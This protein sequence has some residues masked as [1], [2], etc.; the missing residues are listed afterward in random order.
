ME[1]ISEENIKSGNDAYNACVEITDHVGFT[2]AL[3]DF[4]KREYGFEYKDHGDCS[5]HN[6]LVHWTKAHN[7]LA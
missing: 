5:Y 6:R 3:C 2:R 7:T 1:R 4:L